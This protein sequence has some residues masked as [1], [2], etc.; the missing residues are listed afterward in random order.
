MI[1]IISKQLV[2][3]LVLDMLQSKDVIELY[4]RKFGLT[5]TLLVAGGYRLP[6]TIPHN[7]IAMVD[8]KLDKLL[9]GSAVG[10]PHYCTT[11]ITIATDRYMVVEFKSPESE[12]KNRTDFGLEMHTR[13]VTMPDADYLYMDAMAHREL[14]KSH[15][16]EFI[17]FEPQAETA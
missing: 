14:F 10:F 3:P 5:H 16:K 17:L 7:I 4:E 13:G 11:A 12:W 8:N 6:N 1:R 15:I 2:H 9:P